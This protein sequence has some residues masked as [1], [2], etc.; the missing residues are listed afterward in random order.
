[1]C[2]GHKV[3]MGGGVQLKFVCN[4]PLSEFLAGKVKY[5]QSHERLMNVWVLT[6]IGALNDEV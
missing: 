6:I 1:M 3:D 5:C 4:K 2:G